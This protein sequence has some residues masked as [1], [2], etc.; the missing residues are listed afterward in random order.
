MRSSEHHAS[1]FPFCFSPPSPLLKQ[2]G[3]RS[4][5]HD[6]PIPGKGKKEAGGWRAVP[7]PFE[8]DFPELLKHI[9]TDIS[10][11][12]I[13]RESRVWKGQSFNRYLATPSTIRLPLLRRKGRVGVGWVP[14][15]SH[16]HLVPCRKASLYRRPSWH[17]SS[18]TSMA[19]LGRESVVVGDDG[20]V[21]KVD[22]GGW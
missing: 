16:G 21:P 15:V 1:F 2:D 9:S 4:S 7:P 5:G 3:C 12:N 11:Q 22:G 10:W 8:G 18:S 19:N 17:F 20:T 6:T 13:T 14:A